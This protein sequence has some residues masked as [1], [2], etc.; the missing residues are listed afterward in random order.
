M[1]AQQLYR[2]R[3]RSFRVHDEDIMRHLTFFDMGHL[4]AKTDPFPL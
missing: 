1:A 4:G 2:R 3:Q